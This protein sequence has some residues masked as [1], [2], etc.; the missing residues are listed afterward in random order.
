MPSGS[1]WLD[2]QLPS[3]SGLTSPWTTS[4]MPR[5][6]FFLLAAERGVPRQAEEGARLSDGL[7]TSFSSTF[8]IP[9]MSEKA[10]A[11]R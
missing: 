7:A 9:G 8:T 4:A 10:E 5:S 11:V 1:C 2:E 6:L 3:I